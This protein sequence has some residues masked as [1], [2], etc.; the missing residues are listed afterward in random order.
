[1]AASTTT[2][3]SARVITELDSGGT[4]VLPLGAAVPMRLSNPWAWAPPEVDSDSVRL[5]AVA[6]LVD[7]GFAEWVVTAVHGGSARITSLGRSTC[8]SGGSCPSPREFAI[9]ITV[10]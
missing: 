7:P 1:M 10:P 5:A 8:A 3:S 9:E 6:Y 2:P 4:F